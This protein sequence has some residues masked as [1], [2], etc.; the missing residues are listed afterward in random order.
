[1]AL[2]TYPNLLDSPSFPEDAKKRARRILQ[3]CGGNSLGSYSASQ[4]VNCIRED[5]AAYITRRDGGVPADPDNIYLTTGASD[6]ISTILKILVSGGGKS[7]TGV[8][9]PIP[10]YPL[11]SAVIS[12]LDAIQVNYYLDEENC[13]ALNVNELRRAVQ[14]AKDHC[15]P[16]VYR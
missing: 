14:E 7:R 8:M 4:G 13:W 5:V 15:D 2:C 12:E 16:K 6:G 3:A 1:M 11:Y 9:I 10:Q